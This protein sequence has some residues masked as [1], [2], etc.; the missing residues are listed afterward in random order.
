VVGKSARLYEQASL[1]PN[2]M[3]GHPDGGAAVNGGQVAGV[4]LASQAAGPAG[5]EGE[6]MG[7]SQ[8]DEPLFSRASLDTLFVCSLL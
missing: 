1:E 2:P 5:A 6:A 8:S 3:S 4:S 7:P